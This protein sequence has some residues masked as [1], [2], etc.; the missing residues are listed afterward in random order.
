MSTEQSRYRSKKEY[1]LVYT[2][3]ISA[4]KYR[5]TVTY[6]EIAQIMGLPLIGW[7][8]CNMN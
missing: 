6:Q 8:Y 7:D 1:A 4:A 2:Q 5:G 3:L